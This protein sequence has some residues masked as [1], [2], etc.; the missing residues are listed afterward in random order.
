MAAAD[1]VAHCA[2][3]RGPNP[4][5][6]GF[7]RLLLVDSPENHRPPK[8]SSS[9]ATRSRTKLLLFRYSALLAGEA[10]DDN[11]RLVSYSR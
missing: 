9:D 10:A 11:V 8:C 1:A 2:G 3:A 5:N 7:S 6:A 4:L